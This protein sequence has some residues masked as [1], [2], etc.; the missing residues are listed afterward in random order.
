MMV[1]MEYVCGVGLG[2][3]GCIALDV[4]VIDLYA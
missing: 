3:F 1:V 4:F 2:W